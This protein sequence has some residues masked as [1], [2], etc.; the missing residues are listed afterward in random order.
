MIARV[1]SLFAGHNSLIQGFNTFLPQ[2]Y[3]IECSDDPSDPNPIRVTTPQG[4][5]S[6]PEDAQSVFPERQWQQQ[7]PP[8]EQQYGA[9]AQQTSNPNS[10]SQLHAAV[11]ENRS[12]SGNSA[13]VRRSGDPIEFNHA[14][15]YVNKIKARFSAQ[16]DIY[17]TFLEILQTYQRDQLRIG[18]VYSQVTQLFSDAPDLLDDF[19]RFLPDMSQG[20]PTDSNEV[21]LPPVGNFPTNIPGPQSHNDPPPVLTTGRSKKKA[22]SNGLNSETQEPS[23]KGRRGKKKAA[24]TPAVVSPNPETLQDDMVFFERLNKILPAWSF[25]QFMDHISAFT[26][27]RIDKI[28][29][30]KR[31]T[32]I[33][34]SDVH[35]FGWF[36]RYIQIKDELNI[37]ENRPYSLKKIDYQNRE[38][39]GHSYI[40]LSKEEAQGQC[41]GRDDMCWE[42]LN[43]DWVSRPTWNFN[44]SGLYSF[45]RNIFQEALNRVEEERHEYDYYIEAN[46][47]TIQTLESIASRIANM[48]E[49]DKAFYKLNPNLGHSLNVYEN[50]LKR[51]YGETRYH[52]VLE[53]LR[54]NPAISVPVVLRRLKQKDEEWKRGHREW[55]KVWRNIE[56]SVYY[57]SLDYRGLSQ[58]QDDIVE[59]NLTHMLNE[60]TNTRLN[61]LNSFVPEVPNPVKTISVNVF[62]TCVFREVVQLVEA[63]LSSTQ[64]NFRPSKLIPV[65]KMIISSVFTVSIKELS[66]DSEDESFTVKKRLRSDESTTFRE[67]LKISNRKASTVTDVFKDDTNENVSVPSTNTWIKL[68]ISGQNMDE[69]K[70]FSSILY[71][72]KTLYFLLRFI[73]ILA[74]RLSELKALESIVSREIGRKVFKIKYGKD[75]G[76]RNIKL[77]D[78]NFEID[79]TRDIYSQVIDYSCDYLKSDI[80]TEWYEEIVRQTYKNRAVKLYTVA[81]IARNIA[82]LLTEVTDSATSTSLLLA[83]DEYSSESSAEKYYSKASKLINSNDPLFQ[84]RWS[85]SHSEIVFTNLGSTEDLSNEEEDK[86]LMTYAVSYIRNEVS[87]E[88]LADK[89]GK[90]SLQRNIVTSDRS[91][92]V[93]QDSMEVSINS[94]TYQPFFTKDKES[95]VSVPEGTDISKTPVLSK[96]LSNF[97]EGP[98]GWKSDLKESAESINQDK[99]DAWKKTSPEARAVWKMSSGGTSDNSEALSEKEPPTAE[100]AEVPRLQE[101]KFEADSSNI[102]NNTEIKESENKTDTDKGQDFKPKIL[103]TLATDSR[104]EN[105]NSSN[106][107]DTASLQT[108]EQTDLKSISVVDS[109]LSNTNTQPLVEKSSPNQNL[110]VTPDSDSQV[111]I[112]KNSNIGAAAKSESAPVSTSLQESSATSNEK[113]KTEES[114]TDADTPMPDISE[115]PGSENLDSKKSVT[116]AASPKAQTN[117]SISSSVLNDASDSKVENENE[118]ENGSEDKNETKGQNESSSNKEETFKEETKT[119]GSTSIDDSE[120]LVTQDEITTT[121]DN[122]DTN[123]IPKEN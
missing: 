60:I 17:K 15:G 66:E 74:H 56:E 5:I 34:G 24:S 120:K 52:E 98:K 1:S 23:G 107:E 68:A 14:I 38:H 80:S 118:N 61:T 83:H 32:P 94:T 50:V 103:E 2:G 111:N 78:E 108:K 31:V 85:S 115:S 95:F 19:K 12:A 9:Y 71:A 102:S 90:V 7:Q 22:A 49:D 82:K 18:D 3:R 28:E 36:K 121:S 100:T 53:S 55:N 81:K 89:V 75:F 109:G 4:T 64:N 88:G 114:K 46:L 79:G 44:N 16:P 110:T 39:D 29:L 116:N 105:I 87:E 101:N 106:P 42:V 40:K 73:T 47:R 67:V 123:E 86:K 54:N 35:L 91:K 117:T 62:D 33:I 99:F 96:S 112:S 37:I 8:S 119:S 93:T 30:V 43:D 77:D 65:L 92:I 45:H 13:D 58:K 26:E 11:S 70:I 25:N 63:Y 84:L 122:I 57:K 10:M 59:F 51:V 6:R 113:P 72:D 48:T 27:Y 76:I 104:S 69:D 21:R 20:N 97:V 41:S